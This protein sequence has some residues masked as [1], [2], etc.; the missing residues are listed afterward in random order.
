MDWMAIYDDGTA[1]SSA[2]VVT[3][4]SPGAPNSTERRHRSFL[5]LDLTRIKSFRIGNWITY[6]PPVDYRRRTFHGLTGVVGVW[7]VVAMPGWLAIIND[8][9]GRVANFDG[10]KPEIGLHPFDAVPPPPSIIANG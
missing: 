9:D 1:Y 8:A 5:H 10:F 7:H 6:I 4:V 3:V 2:D